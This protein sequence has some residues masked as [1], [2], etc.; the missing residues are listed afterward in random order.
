MVS[1]ILIVIYCAQQIKNNQIYGVIIP[2]NA[3]HAAPFA[4][5]VH[6]CGVLF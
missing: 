4:Y 2:E 3:R 5:F 6:D 1:N